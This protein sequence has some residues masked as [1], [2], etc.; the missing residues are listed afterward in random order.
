MLGLIGRVPG[1]SRNLTS[2][3]TLLMIALGPVVIPPER[4]PRFALVL[5][6]LS[7][8]TYAA[9][10]LRQTMVGPLTA[11]FA[12]DL[13]VLAGI[14]VLSLWVVGQKMNWRRV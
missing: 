14:T 4:L 5:G 8:A 2:V 12:L 1:E 10:A 11:R 9:S 7:P 3:L 13:T 6:H